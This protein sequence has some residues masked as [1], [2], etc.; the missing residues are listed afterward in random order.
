[1][2]PFSSLAGRALRDSRTRT[3]AFAY[4]FAAVAYIQPA[5]YRHS[6]PTQLDRIHFAQSFAGQA[7]LRIFYGVPHDLLT[8]GGYSAWR[9]GGVLSIFA[10]IWGLLAAVRALRAEEEAGRTELV[11][12]G[13]ATRGAAYGASL[14]AIAAGGTLLFAVTFGALVVAGLP[15]GGSAYLALAAVS[16]AAVFSGVGAVSA[17][18]ASTRRL[19]LELGAAAFTLAFL[20]RVVADTAPSLGWLRWATPLG[21][22]E[23][24]RPFGGAQPL[25]LLAPLGASAVLLAG[26]GALLRRRDIGAGLVSARERCGPRMRLL[27]SPTAQ[28]LRSEL[29]SLAAWLGGIGAFALILGIVSH[30]INATAIPAALRRELAKIGDAQIATPAGYL[31][32]CFLLFALAISVFCVG[33]LAA[34]RRE[35]ADE[36]L[37]TLLALPVGR[38]RWLAGRL[39]LAAMGACALAL[40]AGLLAWAGVAQSGVPIPLGR[41]LEAGANCLPAAILFLGAGALAY[42]I[43]PRASTAFAYGLIAVA[44]L[45]MLFGALLGAPHWLLDLSPFEHV[46]LVPSQPF[47]TW[48]AAAMLA[49]G[50]VGACAALAA[51]RRRDLLAA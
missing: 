34:A 16:P 44:F 42:A 15:A 5:A 7:A 43:V 1:M 22:A 51:F 46:A 11:L 47:R 26:A 33:A 49:I 35:E 38:D 18:L 2:S 36:R 6:Y 45:W 40:G 25:V 19:A 24:L 8:V 41:M 37:E 3:L 30:T 27:S 4:L 28:A 10:A 39:A 50:V 31:G 48:S 12:A 17:Q 9:V 13:I 23:E 20:L 21:W 14:A 29:G 32:F